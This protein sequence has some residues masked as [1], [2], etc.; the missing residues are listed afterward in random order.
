M[1]AILFPHMFEEI[2]YLVSQEDGDVEMSEADVPASTQRSARSREN[3]VAGPST[4][5]R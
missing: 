4:L 1:L 3:A 5:V 2:E